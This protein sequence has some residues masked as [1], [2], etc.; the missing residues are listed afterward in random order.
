VR[1]VSGRNQR[2]H[3]WKYIPKL[4]EHIKTGKFAPLEAIPNFIKSDKDIV[5][6]KYRLRYRDG[7]FPKFDVIGVTT[8][9]TFYWRETID[10]I[11]YVKKFCS[12]DV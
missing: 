11:N 2:F 6:K 5:L 12:E 10:T 3:T 4:I 7:R 9:F 1:R 8:L